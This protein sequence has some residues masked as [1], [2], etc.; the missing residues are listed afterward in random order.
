MCSFRDRNTVVQVPPK[1]SAREHV[2]GGG[3]GDGGG[4]LPALTGRI[5]SSS[6]T[7]SDDSDIT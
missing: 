6:G 7:V 2:G 1:H 3:G 5:G 4:G